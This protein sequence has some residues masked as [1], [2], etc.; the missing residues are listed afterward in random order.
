MKRRVPTPTEIAEGMG[1]CADYLR[2]AIDAAQSL[3]DEGAQS[4]EISTVVGAIERVER[5]AAKMA[6]AKTRL[7]CEMCDKPIPID[8]QILAESRGKVARYDSTTCRA[9][10]QKR[11]Y[12]S[13]K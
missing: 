4:P 1:E 6:T 13:G 7:M 9:T 12:R 11:R 5:R 2:G 10:A 8:R 3:L